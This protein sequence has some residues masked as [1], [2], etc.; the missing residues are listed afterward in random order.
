[1]HRKLFWLCLVLLGLVLGSA[2]AA[3]A[4][5]PT[6][7]SSSSCLKAGDT[8]LTARVVAHDDQILKDRTISALGCDLGVYVGPHADGVV[9]KDLSISGAN[10]HGIFVQD[11]KDV[12]ILNDHVYHNGLSP[13]PGIAENKAIELV[14]TQGARVLGTLVTGNLAD[15]GIGIADDG[16]RDPGAPHPGH[17]AA[18][19]GNLVE[20]N[21]VLMNAKGCGIVVAAYDPYAG[22]WDNR[23]VDNQVFGSAPGM[24]PFLGGIIV[25]TD[26]PHTS[27][28]G[29]V[30]ERNLVLGSVLPGVVLHANA[31]GDSIRDTKVSGNTLANNGWLGGPFKTSNDPNLSEG[32]LVIAELFPMSAPSAQIQGTWVRANTVHGDAYGIYVFHAMGTQ[33]LGNT[34]VNARVGI[35]LVQTDLTTRAMSNQLL[36]NTLYGIWIQDGRATA[37]HNVIMGGKW[38]IGVAA[39]H[40][41]THAV[42]HD[43]VIQ[44]VSVAKIRTISQGGNTVTIS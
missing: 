44:D 42:L 36:S 35:A 29:N 25:A 16:A 26:A 30:V 20:D 17:L 15:G 23:I 9:L 3:V 1:M 5:A 28:G 40:T 32:I 11:A 14:G 43:N 21:S 2:T 8:G 24:G 41:A 27:A 22:V 13:T 31:P 38:G 4:G 18:A 37:S 33:V 34:V 6:P 7:T 19:R 39:L 10:D 12:Q